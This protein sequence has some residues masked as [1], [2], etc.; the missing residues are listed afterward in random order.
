MSERDPI[1]PLFESALVRIGSFRCPVEH[2][3]FRDSGPTKSHLFVFPRTCVWIE[4][5]GRRPFVSDPTHAVLYNPQHLLMRA[6]AVAQSMNQRM[7]VGQLTETLRVT[8][9]AAMSPRHGRT[10]ADLLDA[11][12]RAM[13]RARTEGVAFLIAE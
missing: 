12:A 1:R 5:E 10:E 8:I 7:H 9:G 13:S 3:R 11:A 4:Q 6:E 2:P